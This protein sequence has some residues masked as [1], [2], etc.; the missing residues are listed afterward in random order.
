[1]VEPAGQGGVYQ[2]AVAASEIIARTGGSVVLHTARDREIDPAHPVVTCLCVDWLRGVSVGPIRSALAGA[3][4]LLTVAHLALRM[5]HGDVLHF[6]GGYKLPL[7]YLTLIVGRLRSVRIVFS[8]HN[9][10]RRTGESSRML[11]RCSAT[12]DATVVYAGTDAAVIESVGGRPVLAPLVMPAPAVDAA[13]VTTWR[14]RWAAGPGQSV[15]LFAGQIRQDKRLDLLIQAVAGRSDLVLAVVGEDVGAEPAARRLAEEL[16]VSVRWHVGYVDLPEFV[17]S[18]A[19]ADVVACPYDRASQ[20]AVLSMARSLGTATVAS[21]VGGL[22]AL[23][24]VVVDPGDAQ[25]LADGVLLAVGQGGGTGT[26]T[27]ELEQSLSR[28]YGWPGQ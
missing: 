26:A 20:S 4:Y 13:V 2:H 1:M 6:Q 16:D 11:D 7:T 23:A 14:D 25:A 8:P 18:I 21:R 12:A 15:V 10:F 28:A 27:V 3:R 17:A 9:T 24:D 5:R 19:A 22:P